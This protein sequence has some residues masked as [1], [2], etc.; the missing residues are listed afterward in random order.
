MTDSQDEK[1]IE[2]DSPAEFLTG[3]FVLTPPWGRVLLQIRDDAMEVTLVEVEGDESLCCSLKPEDVAS[4]LQDNR[5]VSGVLPES[6][7]GLVG[8]LMQE[9]NWYGALV[10]AEGCPPT[11]PGGVEY[12]MFASAGDVVFSGDVVTIDHEVLAFSAIRDYLSQQRDPADIPNILAKMVSGGEVLVTRISPLHGQP[13]RDVFGRTLDPPVFIEVVVGDHVEL[14]GEESKFSASFFGYPVL[15]DRKLSVISPIVVTDDDMTAWYVQLVQLPPEKSPFGLDL[16]VLLENAGVK[17]ETDGLLVDELCSQLKRGSEPGWYVAARG[18]EPV[19]GKDGRLLFEGTD[20]P[21][22]L[23]DDGSIDFKVINLVK[24]VEANSH[25]ATLSMP[26]AGE[27][28]Y[29]LSDE[30]LPA[31]SGQP[32]KVDAK[33]NVRIDEGEN[34]EIHYYSETEG[35]IQYQNGQ[36]AIDPLYQVK[37]NVDFSTGNIDVDCCLTVAGNVCS[38]FTVKST[39]DTVVNGILEPGSK[40]VVEGDLQVKGGI[41]GE[42]TEVLVLGNLQAEYVQDAKV[43]VKGDILINQYAFSAVIR[44]VGR[45]QVGPGTG[46]RGGSIVG[47]IMCSSSRIE[48]GTTG[49]PSNVLTTIMVEPAPHKLAKLKEMKQRI[50]EY[51][52]NITKIMRTLNLEAVKPDL[53]KQLLQEANPKQRELYVKILNQLNLLVKQQQVLLEDKNQLRDLLWKDVDKMSVLVNK[54]FYSNTKVRIARKE[55]FGR[56]DKGRTTI[57]HDRTRLVVDFAR[58]ND[59]ELPE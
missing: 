58:G 39:K 1:N 31:E 15:I 28:G 50:A 38:D 20:P 6:L 2:D 53:V 23:R 47:G 4:L 24:T 57:T 5:I 52:T 42:N 14:I 32:L 16:A 44:S 49:S 19:H 55:V 35:V 56:Q 34:G 3:E 10:I 45:I 54:V 27:S 25:F 11:V 37:G 9:P 51:E 13:G 21:S 48:A 41:I 12:T 46:E 43:V 29:T 40:I 33:A 26:T 30:E 18:R 7:V 36:L 17:R 22:A 8:D 59:D